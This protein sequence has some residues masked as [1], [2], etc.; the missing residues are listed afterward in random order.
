MDKTEKKEKDTTK[1]AIPTVAPVP[2]V[3]VKTSHGYFHG[4]EC[5]LSADKLS[6]YDLKCK[7][8]RKWLFN[9][10][11]VHAGDIRAINM[12]RSY[13]ALCEEKHRHYQHYPY[14]IH[15]YSKLRVYAEF[16][17]VIL[18]ITSSLV[19]AFHVA[20]NNRNDSSVSM[21]T[22]LPQNRSGDSIFSSNVLNMEHLLPIFHGLYHGGN[23]HTD[24]SQKLL[25]AN[26]GESLEPNH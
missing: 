19:V 20:E 9:I 26:C 7:G 8:V 18:M 6:E 12:H 5:H 17:F 4:H 14:T 22:G 25:V 24:K 23:K 1:T 3:T 10:I 21:K 2:E 16:L 15:P 13:A 11:T